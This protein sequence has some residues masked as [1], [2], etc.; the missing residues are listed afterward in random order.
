MNKNI[1]TNH[2]AWPDA[3]KKLS[4]GVPIALPEW[5]GFWYMHKGNHYV[6]T[7]DNEF[8]DTPMQEFKDRND[9][10]SIE[11]NN[12]YALRF[13]K[14]MRLSMDEMMTFIKN[15]K[16]GLPKN[17]EISLVITE[18]QLA[19]MWLGKI[20]GE[21]NAQNP[22]PE[23]F[24]PDSK[25]IELHADKANK[26][27]SLS[28]VLM[29]MDEIAKVKFM[30]KQVNIYLNSLEWLTCERMA[31][32]KVT[33]CFH[34]IRYVYE[35]LANAKLWLGQQLNNIRE[36]AEKKHHN[37]THAKMPTGKLI[38]ADIAHICHNVNKDICEIHGDHSQLAWEI[39]ADWQRDS[40]ING[41]VFALKNPNATPEDQHNAWMEEKVKDGWAYG[42]TKIP[43]Q[44]LHPC[45]VPYHLLSV[46]QQMKDHAFRAIVF[47]LKPF[48]RADALEQ[49][50]D[51][52]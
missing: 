46:D 9:W 39:A 29:E 32:K 6:F 30:R 16:L 10:E 13:I 12:G 34:A 5:E 2:L 23:S 40:A 38:V 17:R 4:N 33:I 31:E 26:V 24:N 47:S 36:A 15:E 20:L 25:A 14:G 11:M 8:L 7:K 41:V 18:L 22:Y 44:K 35:H 48:L 1:V 21:L 37:T 43:E 50:S 27:T 51:K 3:E 28:R 52:V 45:L 19:F 42:P 49:F